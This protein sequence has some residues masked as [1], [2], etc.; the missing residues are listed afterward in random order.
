MLLSPN[1]DRFLFFFGGGL[2]AAGTEET[3]STG[4][5][6]SEE[7]GAE[8][9]EATGSRGS[10]GADLSSVSDSVSAPSV[11]F[12]INSSSCTSETWK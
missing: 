7:L 3:D 5:T 8:A 4:I 2:G 11:P 1:D 6:F 10:D 12:A 9:V